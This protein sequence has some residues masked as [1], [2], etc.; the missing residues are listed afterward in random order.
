MATAEAQKGALSNTEKAALLLLCMDEKSTGKLFGQL[1]DAEIQKIG[2][3][4]MHLKDVPADKIKTTLAEFFEGMSK[5]GD[6]SPVSGLTREGTLHFDG[7]KIMNKLFGKSLPRQRGES[8]LSGLKDPAGSAI[9]PG[10]PNLAELFQDLNAEFL[11]DILGEEHPQIIALALTQIKRNI[12]KELLDKFSE[13]MQI[14]L[15]DRMARLEQLSGESL[16]DVYVV[17]SE[18]ISAKKKASVGEDKSA[19]SS[20]SIG[21]VGL[22]VQVLKGIGREKSDKMISELEKVDPEIATMISKQMFTIEDL[23]RSDDS[24]IRELLRAVTNEDLKVGLKNAPESLLEKVFKNLS[25]RAAL[26]LKEDMEMLPPQKVEDIEAAQEK[27]LKAAKDL[28][29]EAKMVLADAKTEEG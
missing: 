23:D 18:K 27:I 5:P 25:E 1:Q 21:G 24:G 7:K 26:I 4:L 20:I 6:E 17:L 9:P 11:M 13:E 28:I 3:A 16:K 2:T 29:K 15:I 19:K 8:I 10:G 12:T 22:T 14:D